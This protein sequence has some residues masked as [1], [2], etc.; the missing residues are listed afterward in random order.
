MKKGYKLLTLGIVAL[1]TS[2]NTVKPTTSSSSSSSS[3]TTST[4]TSSTSSSS[5][6][7]STSSSSIKQDIHESE[8]GNHDEVPYY[9]EN[10]IILPAIGGSREVPDPFVYRFNGMYYL[11]P[12]TNGNSVKAYKSRDLIEWEPVDNGQLRTGAVY[13]YSS[14]GSS[15]PK[16]GTPFA[17]EVIYS[18]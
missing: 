4:T 13:E 1:L 11:Y 9:Y 2:C 18:T 16:S 3:S 10:R 6:S 15:A 14:D 7:S 5:T 17:P 8:L 12:T